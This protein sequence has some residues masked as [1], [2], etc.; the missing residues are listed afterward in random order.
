MRTYLDCW[1]DVAAA[2][3]SQALAGEPELAE[4]LPKPMTAGTFG[5]AATLCGDVEGRFAV[6]LDASILDSPLV[7]EGMD[8]RAGWAELLREVADAA[9]GDL[10]A[11]TG[12]KCRVEK[13]EEIQAESKVSR[14]FQ[15]KSGERVFAIL[16][17]DQ[18]CAPQPA[19]RPAVS[20]P[21]AAA[22][23]AQV[24]APQPAI[25]P[26]VE[27]LLD[28]ELEASLRFGC[29][30]MPL[31]QILELGPGDVVQL[32]RHVSDPVDLIVGDKI[33]ARGEVVLVN[34]NFGLR[35]TEVAAPRKTPGEYTMPLLIRRPGALADKDA[36]QAIPDY[37]PADGH[38]SPGGGVGTKRRTPH[39]ARPGLLETCAN[40]DCGSGWLHLWRSRSTPVFEHGWSCSSACTR[41]LLASAV[42]REMAGL[43]AV[44]EGHRHRIPLGLVMLEQ[45]WITPAQLRRA[46]EAQK[47]AGG[48][49]LGQWL[50]QQQGVG[51]QFVT[52]ALGLQWSCPVLPVEFHDAEAMAVLVP[53]LFIDAFAALPLRVAAGKLL[54]MGFEDRLDP[55]LAFA[56]ERMTGLRV[57]SGLVQ[58]SHFRA[59]HGR[60]LKAGFPSVE[61]IEAVSEPAAVHA[62][63]KALER[64]RPVESQ[65]VRVHD[66]L[67]LRMWRRPQ[68]GPLPERGQVQD[69]ICAV[70]GRQG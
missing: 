1:I 16:V 26:G 40:P 70:G 31:G 47:A 6:I 15:L 49:R 44:D 20:A 28:V 33:V 36:R 64:A 43:G 66:C 10:L 61:L 65:L 32:D 56:V 7:G 52:R 41:E 38:P 53:R 60:A 35:V 63:A 39:P 8:Q 55:V 18:V 5:F 13:F 54:Y 29:R 25:N 58:G 12:T 51:E 30:E 24:S 3:F 27:L 48:G 22:P 23:P 19:G 2:L 42:R 59:A 17:R 67:W 46:L 68:Q 9:A 69:L 34:G 4:S 14:A 50:V 45:G 37:F 11:K 62:L 21:S 57:E